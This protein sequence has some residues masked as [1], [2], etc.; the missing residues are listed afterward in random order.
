MQ[1]FSSQSL[2]SGT[3]INI[4]SR[5]AARLLRLLLLVIISLKFGAS[6]ETDAYFIAQSIVLFFAAFG[7]RVINLTFVPVFVDYA[8]KHQN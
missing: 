4:G 8:K 5:S 6:R 2:Y 7:D 1:V 3:I